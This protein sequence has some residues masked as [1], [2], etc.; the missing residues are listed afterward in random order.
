MRP[1]LLPLHPAGWPFI[2]AFA[3]ATLILLSFSKILGLLA[4]GATAWC[5][6][7]FRNPPR[8]T[9]QGKDLV[10]SPADGLLVKIEK[11]SPPKEVK[12]ETAPLTR[13]SIFLNV[14]DV[15]VTRCPLEGVIKKV[16]YHPGK[17]L[18]ASL[19][20]ASETNERNS[21]VIKTSSGQE[22]L[23]VQ[24]AG[25]IARRIVCEVSENQEVKAGD[26]VGIIRFGSRVDIYL[27]KGVSPQVLE[28]QRMVGGETVLATLESAHRPSKS[29]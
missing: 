17:F 6:C 29:K 13:L 7:F 1:P 15:H 10:I 20:K 14:F 12:W 26:V 18:N 21:L 24:I 25:L 2:G 23:V 4:L 11:A 8:V 19:D 9:P 28:G 27:P 5:V 22:I 16:V 3:V